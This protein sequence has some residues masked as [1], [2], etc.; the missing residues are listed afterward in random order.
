MLARTAVALA[1]A[2]VSVALYVGSTPA[3]GAGAERCRP[4][5]STCSD[6]TG[7][8]ETP[9]TLAQRLETAP[10]DQPQR[11]VVLTHRSTRTGIQLGGMTLSIIIVVVIASL[12]TALFGTIVFL[13]NK[14]MDEPEVA[15]GEPPEA[16][17]GEADR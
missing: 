8:A 17:D 9:A 11:L 6:R 12:G 2:L 5:S 15:P 3:E 7:L 4:D 10:D 13:V 14:L 16:R 1:I